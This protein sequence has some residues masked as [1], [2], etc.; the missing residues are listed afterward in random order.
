MTNGRPISGLKRS[1]PL[2]LLRHNGP[3]HE[4]AALLR[5]L[6]ERGINLAAFHQEAVSSQGSPAWLLLRPED[7][8]AVLSLARDRAR[9]LGEPPP[10]EPLPVETFTLYPAGRQADLSILA[11]AS[12]HGAGADALASCTS[13]SALVLVLPAENAE[14]ALSVLL[15]VFPLPPGVSPCLETVRVVQKP[16]P[17]HA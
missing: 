2:R 16:R 17:A 7:S 8:P 1:G 9:R 12:L 5:D 10:A 11:H 6:A 15:A 14:K 13:L 4:S 3:P